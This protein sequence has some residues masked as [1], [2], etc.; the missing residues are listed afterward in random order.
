MSP[1]APAAAAA[2]VMW[3]F[4]NPTGLMSGFRTPPCHSEES[5]RRDSRT[6]TEG[7]KLANYHLICPLSLFWG[8][9]LFGGL[10][11]GSEATADW[12]SLENE[13]AAM[14][15][16]TGPAKK[17]VVQPAS[18]PSTNSNYLWADVICWEVNLGFLPNDRMNCT[19]D[20]DIKNHLQSLLQ[21]VS[22]KT[23][24]GSNRFDQR[25]ASPP[26]LTDFSV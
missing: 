16:F 7:A 13:A 14:M 21:N 2:A 12:T 25:T 15:L 9:L 17:T 5:P 26:M 23:W 1:V 10:I 24:G 22:K 11:V 4:E 6:S 8:S 20:G 3:D 18:C 19:M